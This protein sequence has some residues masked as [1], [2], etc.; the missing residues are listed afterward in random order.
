MTYRRALDIDA[1]VA[2]VITDLHGAWEPYERLRD[3]FFDERARGQAHYFVV[4]GDMIHA[5]ARARYADESLRIVHDLMALQATYGRNVVI[6]LTGNHE[7]PHIYG[8]ELQKEGRSVSAG[9]EWAM[10]EAADEPSLPKRDEVRAFFRGLPFYVRTQAGVTLSHAGASP[11]VTREGALLELLNFDHDALLHWAND[12]IHAQYD[13]TRMRTSTAYLTLA[14]ERLAIQGADD[15]RLSELL[16]SEIVSQHEQFALLW[17]AFFAANERSSNRFTY[18]RMVELFLA[19]MTA[20]SPYPQRVLTAG[21]VPIVRGGYQLLGAQKLRFASYAHASP[22]K[23][24]VYLRLDC[25]QPVLDAD[26]L[27]AHLHPVF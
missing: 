18:L 22:P 5:P 19:Q 15:P 6:V 12:V 16:A 11:I 3:R 27:V 17:D 10:H 14:R 4:C 13:V 1:G 25:E 2:L 20:F 7:I 21:H 26:A 9:F 24:G 23:S 8:F